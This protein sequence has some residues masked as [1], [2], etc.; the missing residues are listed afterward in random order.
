MD[1]GAIARSGEGETVEFKERWNESALETL[2]AFA[3]TRAAPSWSGWMME[4][5]WLVGPAVRA[6]SGRAATRLWMPWLDSGS[7]R[8]PGPRD[9]ELTTFS[10]STIGAKGAS[11]GRR[12]HNTSAGKPRGKR[13]KA[14]HD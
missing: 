3:N 10:R 11:K 13:R 8:G 5:R 4:D 14:G 12:E 9:V 6:T 2:A 7:L 1:V